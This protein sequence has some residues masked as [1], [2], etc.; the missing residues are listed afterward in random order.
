MY[1]LVGL[2][3]VVFLLTACTFGKPLP[4]G[5]KAPKSNEAYFILGLS[6]PEYQ[7]QI[8]R[9]SINSDDRFH[10]HPFANASL[11]GIAESGYIVGKADG[12]S[13]LAITRVYPNASDIY[14]SF[15][16]CEDGKTVVFKAIGGKVIYIADIEYTLTNNKLMLGYKD[17]INGA[18]KYLESEYPDLASSLMQGEFDIIK[19]TESCTSTI[20]VPI[21]LPR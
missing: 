9:G 2:C 8:F 18:K 16:P 17:N 15:I 3:F 14:T 7:I 11:N 5:A 19:T 20:Y 21:S 12:G 10:L 13:F 6:P 4:K 1:K